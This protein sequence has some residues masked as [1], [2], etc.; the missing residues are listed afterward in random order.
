MGQCPVAAFF[1]AARYILAIFFITFS[2]C[3]WR[4]FISQGQAL[5]LEAFNFSGNGSMPGCCFSGP[6][7]FHVGLFLY[8]F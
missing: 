2:H 4:H 3:A 1:A 5:A 8:H 6:R 7:T